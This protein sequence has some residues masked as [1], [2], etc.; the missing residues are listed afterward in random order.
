VARVRRGQFLGSRHR[1]DAVP[2]CHR[3]EHLP[4]RPRR[5]QLRDSREHGVV[6]AE[7]AVQQRSPR[8]VDA[9]GRGQPAQRLGRVLRRRYDEQRVWQR[10]SARRLPRG[11]VHRRRVR[12]EADHERVRTLRRG[13]QHATSVAGTEVHLYASEA[14][15]Q[16]SDEACVDLVDAAASNDPEHGPDFTGPG[17]VYVGAARRMI[18][19]TLA[20][21][22]GSKPAAANMAGEPM[23]SPRSCG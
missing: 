18:S 1:R 2:R 10:A 9:E 17:A 15:R 21:R 3:H 14:A 4:G 16:A 13:G 23:W 11:L 8:E 7:D 6:A 12:I 5:E 20:A 22:T 19:R